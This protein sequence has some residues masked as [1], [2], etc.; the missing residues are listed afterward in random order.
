MKKEKRRSRRYA[1]AFAF[2]EDLA[3]IDEY[4]S[5]RRGKVPIYNL[6]AGFAVALRDGE[7]APEGYE[8]KFKEVSY[9]YAVWRSV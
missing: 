7:Q 9:G 5:T 1:I 8:W 6:G 3:D 2:G 4:Q